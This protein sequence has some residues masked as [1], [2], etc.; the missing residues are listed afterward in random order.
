MGSRKKSVR[1]SSAG[2]IW[3]NIWRTF[4]A[5]I[6][7]GII[8][9]CIIASVSAVY[10]LR[11]VNSDEPVSL[12]NLDTLYTSII[13]AMD[14]EG[15]PYE[16]QRLQTQQNRIPITYDQLPKHVV[17]ALVAT[18]DKRFFE[19]HGVDWQ[20]SFV[21]FVNMFVPV[22]PNRQG[23]STITQQLVKNV[24]GDDENSVERKIQEIFRALNLEQHYSKEQIVEAYLNTV[25][26]SNNAYGIQ[27][28]ANTYFGKDVKD[29]T[30][31]EAAAIIGITKYPGAFDPFTNRDKNKGRQEDVLFLM[32]EQGKITDKEYE[33][34]LVEKL[35]FS[36]NAQDPNLIV[37]PRYSYFVDYVVKQVVNDLVE[38][39][40][41]TEQRA[42]QL[43]TS[44][45]YRIYTTVDP[46][47]QDYLEEYYSSADNFPKVG[48]AE[49]PQSACVITDPNGKILALAGAV[50]EKTGALEYSRA[51]DSRRQ[52]GSS[53]K[54]IAAYLMGIENDIIT[55]S[56]MMDDLPLTIPDG[57]GGTMQW[58]RNFQGNY[59]S[60]DGGPKISID[61]AIQESRN[62]IPA[63]L[64]QMV[65]PQRTFD[66]LH[67]KL[68]MESL[69]DPDDVNP[70]SMA[71]GGMTYGVSPLEMAGAYQIYA[72]GGYF[73][74]PYAYTEVRDYSGNIIL[75]KDTSPRRVISAE[76]ATIVNKLMQRVTT[77]PYGTGTPARFSTSMPI[78]G[79]TGTSSED[80][81]QWFVGV[82]PYYVTTIWLGYDTNQTIRYPYGYPPPLIYKQ[83]MGTLHEGLEPIQFPDWSNG[84]VQ[85]HSYCTISG[86]LPAEGCPVS[87]SMGWY[88]TSNMPPVCSG[89]VTVEESSE[90]EP[91]GEIEDPGDGPDGRTGGVQDDSASKVVYVLPDRPKKD[92]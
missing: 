55:W 6:M 25:Y 65:T 81:D 45:G 23:G 24:T 69:V 5:F 7:V 53:I 89:H 49:Y 39:K 41:Y 50:G 42:R 59:I 51:T 44:G 30:I 22:L 13:Y 54:P 79:K 61:R 48:N 72:N 21:A 9:G 32:H 47:M 34:A 73:T 83:V 70:S 74:K 85:A 37:N 17:D 57:H 76:T 90:L 11:Y 56:T 58:P 78:A 40:G 14:E 20:R 86:D 46:N 19:H 35:N 31:A 4:A 18:E 71:L 62:T 82:T 84:N 38:E 16:L 15:N 66:F 77:G 64:I 43:V 29:L 80:Y 1:K 91:G 2:N 26:F 87:D 8:T 28:A 10:I 63:Q 68:G 27:A 75:K 60:A 36:Y 3:G 52:T 88:K 92:D 33:D 12:D 67:D